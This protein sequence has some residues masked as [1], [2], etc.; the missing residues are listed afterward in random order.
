MPLSPFQVTRKAIES[1]PVGIQN[2]KLRSALMLALKDHLASTARN[3]SQAATLF[4]VPQ[5]RI[6]ELMRGRIHQFDLESL[7]GMAAMAGLRIEM[8][9]VD[10]SGE[11]PRCGSGQCVPAMPNHRTRHRNLKPSR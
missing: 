2:M 10:A 8:Q 9:I 4:G 6:A 7:I 5:A 3:E 11:Q 1:R